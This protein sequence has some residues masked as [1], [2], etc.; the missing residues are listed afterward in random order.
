MESGSM[1]PGSASS[2]NP[3]Q[4]VPHGCTEV[5]SASVMQQ[6]STGSSSPSR[7]AAL[8]VTSDTHRLSSRL[9]S[10]MSPALAMHR[11]ERAPGG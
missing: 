9:S 11:C 4:K 3:C 2:R 5:A 10:L 1:L 6:I 8:K 7:H